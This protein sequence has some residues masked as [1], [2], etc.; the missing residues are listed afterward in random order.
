MT[1]DHRQP[2][3]C[4]AST[5][6]PHRRDVWLLV[7][8]HP[9][10][11][12]M[13][14]V[15]ALRNILGSGRRD[16]DP[17]VHVL[18][19]S[20]GD[21]EDQWYGPIRTREM[22][23]AC[24]L[25]GVQSD[26]K[27]SSP[28]A[29]R[30]L[31][32]DRLQDGPNEV[33]NP[34][35]VS[36][37]VLHHIREQIAPLVCND[38][39]PT[40][41]PKHEYMLSEPREEVRAWAVEE[42]QPAGRATPPKQSVRASINLKL[43]TFDK[44]GVS[45]HPNHL[46]TYRGIR[47]MLNEKCVV[48]RDRTESSAT[49]RLNQQAD[50]A[51][52]EQDSTNS[53]EFHVSAYSLITIANPLQKYF[54]WAFVDILPYLLLRLFHVMLYLTYFLLGGPLW[55]KGGP[56]CQPFTRMEA[57]L[58]ANNVRCRLMEPLLVWKAMAA[59]RSQF[60]WYRRLSVMFSRY[61]FINDLEKMPIDPPPQ[62]DCESDDD[63]ASLPPVVTINEEESSAEFLL[64]VPQMNA[65]REAVLPPG[66]HHRPW[67]RVYSLSRDGDSFVAFRKLL[68]DWARENRGSAS[69]I[70]VV[71]TGAGE[72]IGGFADASLVPLASDI[73]GSANRSCLFCL[74]SQN[75]CAGPILKVY[76]KRFSSESSKKLVFDATR[77]IIAFG[78]SNSG[79]GL[80]EGFG[81]CLED[82][83]GRGTTA[84]CAA[85]QNDPLVSNDDG[86]FEVLDV[87]VWG[88]VFGQL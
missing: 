9:D 15:P 1:A 52:S 21:Y 6:P 48:T 63:I 5:T 4:P 69:T 67:K 81:L 36:D 27:T 44:G 86:V 43:L 31:N 35:V 82:G 38:V 45:G 8:A 56:Q 80:D 84:R 2:E 71:K 59:H 46:D 47:H 68:E 57:S 14:F 28:S 25:I 33:W 24:S 16:G 10:D 73:A 37:S 79:D 18:C 32:D 65:L 17:I 87:E 39:V 55:S 61:T 50:S 34:D 40:R 11:E 29:A 66:L 64:D 83:F 42:K 51:A 75:A 58:D 62:L 49:L 13:F 54:L 23:R 74:D 85:F 41:S 22:H 70:L 20:N 72:T 60:V 77:R 76:G 26:G 19:L 88:F 30:V 3:R 7:T 78:G 12:S 53:I